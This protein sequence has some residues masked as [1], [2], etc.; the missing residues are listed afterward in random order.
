MTKTWKHRYIDLYLEYKD[1]IG[2]SCC[3]SIYRSRS[4]GK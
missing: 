4:F 3:Y 1:G 2:Y